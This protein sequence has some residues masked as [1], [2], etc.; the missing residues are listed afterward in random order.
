MTQRPCSVLLWLFLKIVVIKDFVV[1]HKKDLEFTPSCNSRSRHGSGSHAS[2]VLCIFVFA[3][4]SH[5]MI[6]R[7]DTTRKGRF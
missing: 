1:Y 3:C 5:N 2:L 7:N 6:I 4:G